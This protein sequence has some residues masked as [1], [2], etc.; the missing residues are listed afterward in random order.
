MPKAL[1]NSTPAEVENSKPVESI[2]PDENLNALL[3]P[4]TAKTFNSLNQE[5]KGF[6]VNFAKKFMIKGRSLSKMH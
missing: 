4:D 3:A 2:E 5:S 1:E 6:L